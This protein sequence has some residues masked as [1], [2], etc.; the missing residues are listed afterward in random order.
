[1]LICIRHKNAWFKL[2]TSLFI[3]FWKILWYNW[4]L[5]LWKWVTLWYK[6]KQ[7]LWKSYNFR[8]T[9]PLEL[10]WSSSEHTWETWDPDEW[11]CVNEGSSFHSLSA[12]PSRRAAQEAIAFRPWVLHTADHMDSIPWQ[13]SNM[14]PGCRHLWQNTTEATQND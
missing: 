4:T 1:M 12:W 9:T 13:Y 14:V 3:S 5:A 8:T 7:E 6:Q 10:S 11:S 2:K